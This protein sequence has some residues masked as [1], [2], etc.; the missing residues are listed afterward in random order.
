[1]TSNLNRL[2]SEI[3]RLAKGRFVRN[4]AVVTTGAATAQVI[5]IAFAPIITRLY[6]PEA[7]GLLGT[8]MT[9]VGV[10]TTIAALSYP[11]AI[12]LPKEDSDARG[13][14]QLSVYISLV[15]AALV[16]VALLVGGD[17]LLNLLG[18]Q[19]I[20]AF[21]LLIPLNI[22]FAAWLQVAQQWLIRKK[23]FKVKAKVA[24]AQAMIL[25][26]AKSGIGLFAP[27]AAV[28]IVLTTIGGALHAAML[29]WGAR[30]GKDDANGKKTPNKQTPLI[31]LAKQYYDFPLYRAPQVFIN[32][33]SRSLP[34]L[35]L[36]ALFG[37]ASAGFY[38]LG[39]RVLGLPSQLISMSVYE[40]FYPRITAAL[41]NGENLTR[42]ILKST[43]ALAGL[44]VVPFGIIVVFGPWL[45]GLIFGEQWVMAGE[46]SR[47]L[48]IFSF[49]L[50]I[51]RPSMAA[52]PVLGLQRGL[53]VYEILSTGSK[54][55]ALY[56]GF[57]YF[58]DD[59]VAVALFSTFGATAY[60]FLIAWVLIISRYRVVKYNEPSKAIMPD[61]QVA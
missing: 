32:S 54:L 7:F 14:A 53:L 39:R 21:I 9:L 12:V 34:V 35:M 58:A 4:V 41:H 48:A 56:I 2:T 18:A 49:F 27:L 42:L 25:N 5:T 11:I 29:S 61:E 60:I 15:V 17:R 51:N 1:M 44:G 8:F 3:K 24:V 45:F 10:L 46:Y 26:T 57:V 52:V 6:G 37:P 36:A 38:V 19:A 16:A 59:R 28:L 40:V 30:V 33:I 20:A 31:E 13:L 43:V 50:F 47:W 22:L 23:Q 55:L